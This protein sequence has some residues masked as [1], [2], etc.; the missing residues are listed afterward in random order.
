MIYDSEQN[1][2]QNV[3]GTHTSKVKISCLMLGKKMTSKKHMK[4]TKTTNR[5]LVIAEKLR[6]KNII[7]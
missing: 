5:T 3:S 2:I 1:K 4:A 7:G 6:R